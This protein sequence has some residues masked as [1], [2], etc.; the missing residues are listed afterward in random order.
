MA[1]AHQQ[2]VAAAAAGSRSRHA[3]GRATPSQDSRRVLG[4][5]IRIHSKAGKAAK[6]GPALPLVDISKESMAQV[7][8]WQTML[9]YAKGEYTVFGLSLK[10]F[11]FSTTSSKES[12]NSHFFQNLFVFVQ[13]IDRLSTLGLKV[14]KFTN[15][16]SQYFELLKYKNSRAN[17]VTWS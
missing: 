17:P 11:L 9:H 14:S 13:H 12:T 16:D 4:K 7:F 6:R 3:G 2:N 10:S 5:P 8:D 1:A 15:W